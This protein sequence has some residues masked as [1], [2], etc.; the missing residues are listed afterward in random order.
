MDPSFNFQSDTVKN[1]MNASEKL[2]KEK[3]T[4][5]LQNRRKIKN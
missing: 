4:Q 2:R 1:F 3:R 5:F